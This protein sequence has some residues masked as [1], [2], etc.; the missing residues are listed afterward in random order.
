M[1]AQYRGVH[2]SHVSRSGDIFKFMGLHEVTWELIDN[3]LGTLGNITSSSEHKGERSD[4]L[5]HQAQ[6]DLVP[7]IPSLLAPLG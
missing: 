1:S 2:F 3:F 4:G 6:G 7:T 5:W